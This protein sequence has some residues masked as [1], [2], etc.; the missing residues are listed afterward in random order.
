MKSNQK[1]LIVGCGNMGRSHARAYTQLEGVQIC[2]LV[3][4]RESKNKL[5]DEL[6]IETELYNSIEEALAQSKPDIVVISTYP[7]T[8]ED[9]AIQSLEAGAH[10]FLEKPVSPT[11]E[12]CKRV[13]LKAKQCNRKLV[14]GYILRHHPSWRT[15]TQKAKTLGKPLV[16]RMNLNQQ[17][18]GEMWNTHKNLMKSMP[19][20]VDCG[21]HYVDIMCQMTEARPT[22]VHAIGVKLTDEIAPHMKNYGQLQVT[23]EDGSVGWYEAGWGPMMSQ[24]AFFVKDV[25]G[26]KGSVSIVTKEASKEGNSDSVKAHTKTESL[27]VHYSDLNQDGS[28]AI[29]DEWVDNEEEPDHDGLCLLEQEHLLKAIRE[30]LDLSLHHQQAL[31]SLKVVL[32]ADRSI[33]EQRSITLV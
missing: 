3:A 17:S 24:T 29:Q 26:P 33:K 9:Y 4:R 25:V 14:I 13:L 21:V 10:V 15:F 2:G 11:L 28:F 22:R 1:V 31:D 18:Q 5:K 23:F 20:I 6:N 7:D 16:M 27:R 30:D 12:G 19:P 32:A 8:H